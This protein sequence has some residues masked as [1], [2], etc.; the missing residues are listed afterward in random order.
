[1]E[2]PWH[3]TTD[4]LQTMEP[5][6]QEKIHLEKQIE[7]LRVAN[8]YSTD[9]DSTEAEYVNGKDNIDNDDAGTDFSNDDTD[10][11]DAGTKFFR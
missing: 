8:N 11:N 7:R 10:D 5:M 4:K 2:R 3:A 1:M 6:I 9:D